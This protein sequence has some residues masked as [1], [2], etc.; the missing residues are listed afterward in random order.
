MNLIALINHKVLLIGF[1]SD[2]LI[3]NKGFGSVYFKSLPR[4]TLFGLDFGVYFEIFRLV[5]LFMG[6]DS[7]GGR[8]EELVGFIG[9]GGL[10]DLGMESTLEFDGLFGGFGFGVVF[11]G[12]KSISK[13]HNNKFVCYRVINFINVSNSFILIII[14]IGLCSV[15]Y[16]F[17]YCT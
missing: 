7:M 10:V 1:R 4:K 5:G 2:I 3:Q 12:G 6:L 14:I 9:G 11:G 16:D 17:M 8:V 13:V 15:I